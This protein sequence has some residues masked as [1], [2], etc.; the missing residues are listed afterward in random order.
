MHNQGRIE[1]NLWSDAVREKRSSTTPP[2]P[3]AAEADL[4]PKK[5][6]RHY[7]EQSIS[8]KR[9]PSFTARMR[10]RA[11]LKINCCCTYPLC[12]RGGAWSFYQRREIKDILAFMRMVHSGMD[13]VS[14]VRTI[15]LP[16]RGLGEATIDKLRLASGLEQRSIFSYCANSSA[17]A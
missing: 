6:Q 15:N 2:I 16:K 10:S 3:S 1:K 7:E 9:W 5:I 17:A 11:P 8:L 14:F 12:H 13:Y 4:S